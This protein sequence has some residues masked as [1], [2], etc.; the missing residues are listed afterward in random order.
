MQQDQNEPEGD[1]EIDKNSAQWY[2]QWWLGL[3]V[4]SWDMISTTDL[5]VVGL[6]SLSD[7]PS[8]SGEPTDGFLLRHRGRVN[9]E[10]KLPEGI[11]FEQ[12][13]KRIFCEEAFRSVFLRQ[14]FP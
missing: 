2:L 5:G 7:Y 4:I 9:S 12:G 14:E 1:Q 6:A 13:L 10:L 8:C 3:T 11:E